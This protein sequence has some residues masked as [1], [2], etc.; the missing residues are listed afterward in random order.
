MATTPVDI[1]VTN[2]GMHAPLKHQKTKA[3]AGLTESLRTQMDREKRNGLLSLVALVAC[4]VIGYLAWMAYCVENQARTEPN[5]YDPKVGVTMITKA[6]DVHLVPGPGATIEYK[7]PNAAFNQ[8]ATK[9]ST[10]TNVVAYTVQNDK[11]CGGWPRGA[12]SGDCLVT[13][14]V[15]PEAKSSTFT[16]EQLTTDTSSPKIKVLGAEIGGIVMGYDHTPVKSAAL[17]LDKA[18]VS[19]T[20]VGYLVSG[21]LSAKDSIVGDFAFQTE[22]GSITLV[23]QPAPHGAPVDIGFRANHFC[24]SSDV[25]MTNY[26]DLATTHGNPW[27]YCDYGKILRGESVSKDEGDFLDKLKANYDQN[28]DGYVSDA[29]ARVGLNNMGCY[30]TDCPFGSDADLV[31]YQLGLGT[32]IPMSGNS[33]LL[34]GQVAE[35]ILKTNNTGWAPGCKT[36]VRVQASEPV[37]APKTTLA[38]PKFSLLEAGGEV[39]VQLK[40]STGPKKDSRSLWYPG[41]GPGSGLK[42]AGASAAKMLSKYATQYGDIGSSDSLFL[43][44]DVVGSPGVPKSRWVYATNPAYLYMDP[45]MLQALSP[46]LAP[47]VAREKIVFEDKDCT[48]KLSDKTDAE[49]ELAYADIASQLAQG[50]RSNPKGRGAIRGVLV[51]LDDSVE[52][53]FPSTPKYYTVVTD[54]D[55]AAHRER[56]GMPALAASLDVLLVVAWA[57]CISLGI[58]TV[59]VIWNYAQHVAKNSYQ[60]DRSRFFTLVRRSGLPPARVKV[61]ADAHKI[62]APNWNG[63]YDIPGLLANAVGDHYMHRTVDML[64]TFMQTRTYK[65]AGSEG[66]ERFVYLRTLMHWYEIH[67]LQ[68][69]VN[70]Y[71]FDE[72]SIR[73][74]LIKDFDLRVQQVKV[75]RLYGLAWA[76][77]E[78]AGMDDTA[79]KAAPDA[80]S[81]LSSDAVTRVDILKKFIAE[82]CIVDASPGVF[83]DFKTRKGPDGRLLAGFSPELAAWCKGK[84]L[85]PPELLDESLD[86]ESVLPPQASLH[87]GAVTKV[88]GIVLRMGDDDAVE[89]EAADTSMSCA[90]FGLQFIT[91]SFNSVLLTFLP[92]CFLL[93]WILTYQDF[94]GWLNVPGKGVVDVHGSYRPPLGWGNIQQLDFGFSSAAGVYV[95]PF[96]GLVIPLSFLFLLSLLRLVAAS[97]QA[98]ISPGL[99]QE[100]RI[101]KFLHLFYHLNGLLFAFML[102]VLF[103][104]LWLQIS[105]TILAAC[106]YPAEVAPIGAGVIGAVYAA[107]YT[108]SAAMARLKKLE[109]S[110][111]E[112]FDMV[113]QSKLKAALYRL[114]ATN[115]MNGVAAPKNWDKKK[116]TAKDL[117]LALDS[118]ATGDRQEG[119]LT[120]EDIERM[121]ESFDLNLSDHQKDSFFANTDSDASGTINATEFQEG[122]DLMMKGMVMSSLDGAGFTRLDAFM[123]AGMAVLCLILLTVFVIMGVNAFSG[124]NNVSATLQSLIIAGVTS[125]VRN[126]RRRAA[127]E[128]DSLAK[129]SADGK[130]V[131]SIVEK[132]QEV[133]SKM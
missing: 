100:M 5:T 81:A 108:Y 52:P 43:V 102:F 96:A 79:K 41:A 94:W 36:S 21:S 35:A 73:R 98:W 4:C 42:M 131:S 14:T 53:T 67:C 68:N 82:K 87:E 120:T 37:G 103:T 54:G 71:D 117:F 44:M 23:D 70:K 84:G 76:G 111:K 118:E 55:G 119:T 47:N 50:F 101:P 113:L 115:A 11:G 109:A 17:F 63:F 61:F 114:H 19:G 65:P 33:Q 26:K 95:T 9:D 22:K 107:F 122:W 57:T 83:I 128:Q 15:P 60:A 49:V 125:Q 6:C 77:P 127:S 72:N 13:V 106:I 58:L 86:W 123:A 29:E 45:A 92:A 89:K 105:W 8:A 51:L 62:A 64:K 69:K 80:D 38:T 3:E 93:T 121:F 24:V 132:Q 18:T 124:T 97:L 88:C 126:A 75:M 10:G 130:L 85:P 112:A 90:S 2:V 59:F 1:E 7:A 66:E 16:F 20:I 91:M 74:R 56:F 40:Q 12:C 48:Y 99:I 25:P 39:I 46:Q 133:A 129:D 32:I 31:T 104:M 110:I 116:L 30:G 78:K 27:H 34:T 28:S